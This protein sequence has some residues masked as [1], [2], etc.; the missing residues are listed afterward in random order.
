MQASP[1]AVLEPRDTL[2]QIVCA[3]CIAIQSPQLSYGCYGGQSMGGGSRIGEQLLRKLSSSL[4]PATPSKLAWTSL[5]QLSW[6][7]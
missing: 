2:T 7:P 1:D 5:S 3:E 4:S 6:E